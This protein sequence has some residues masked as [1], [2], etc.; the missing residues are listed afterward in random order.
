MVNTANHTMR[1][2]LPEWQGYG[3]SS[4][5]AR[6][7]RLLGRRLF[8][9]SDVRTIDTPDDEA[10]TVAGGVLGLTSL[11]SRLPETRAA[12]HASVPDRIFTVGATCGVEVA[13]IGYLNQ[14]Y[15]DDVAVVWLDAH[16]DLNTPASAPSGHFHEMVLRT[17]LGDGPA[18]LTDQIPRPLTPP[19]LYLAGLRDLDPPEA[20]FVRG[21]G[22]RVVGPEVF[23]DPVQFVRDVRR[24][25]F[26]R[27]YLHLDLDVVNPDDFAS[28]LM[29]TP[30]GPSLD[31]VAAVV[32]Q[33]AE[34]CDIAGASV[35]EFCD[36]NDQDAARVS[37]A[38]STLFQ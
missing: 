13:P 3:L 15:G 38:V 10:L 1:L 25:G 21:A 19:Q 36:R 4:L 34:Q 20:D 30:G 12:I 17:L 35:V 29:R 14:K 11:A 32:C 24:A 27:V 5:P 33:L 23:A 37:E 8:A 31:D 7:A 18:S 9:G 2:V 28:S 22:I 16:A 26:G 6:G